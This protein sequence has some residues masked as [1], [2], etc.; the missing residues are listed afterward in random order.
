[1][2]ISVLGC[3]YLGAVHAA[4]MAS[5]GHEVVGIDV[6][7]A[8]VRQLQRGEAPF[9]E[10]G[11]PEILSAGLKSG[12]LRFEV[13]AAAAEN[14][15]VHF[16]CV[17]TPQQSDGNAADLRFV[18]EAV[19]ALLPHLRG[20]D[21]LVGKSTVPV[22]T[23]EWL[24]SWLRQRGAD[25]EVVWNP[26]FLREGTAVQDTM[27]PDRFVYGAA[28]TAAGRRAKAVL[29]EVYAEPL[30]A[31]VPKI[32][33]DLA[34][35]QL[36]KMAANS[37]L[38]TKISFINAMA[39]IC[40]ASGGDVGVLASALGMDE[41][42]G[43]KFLSAGLGF[44]GGCLPKD[45][46]AFMARAD[47]LA[48]REAVGLLREVDAINVRRRTRMVALADEVCGGSLIGRRVA[49]LG[50]AFKPHS[51][52]VRDS[53]ALDVAE[54]LQALGADVVVTDPKAVDTAREKHPGLKLT[55][56]TLEA[57]A[58]AELVMLLTEWPEYRELDPR[59]LFSQVSCPIM[60]DGRNCLDAAEWRRAGWHYRAFGRAGSA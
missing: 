27:M 41:R 21:I 28:D 25:T 51:D 23:A 46:R 60:I 8:R 2:K 36:V 40:D 45:V 7:P 19:R 39:D 32:E 6:D 10:P 33:A 55:E 20:G 15:D 59:T 50:A 38:A 35:A 30:A 56:N 29:D 17:G 58:D 54:Q 31:G 34:T 24:V 49:V 26:E 12:R 43:P 57:L 44:G 52:D 4:C 13:D 3:G 5:F 48:A 11:F 37:F 16:L 14:R 22:G 9:F 42:I 1:M 53:P 18:Q 47:E